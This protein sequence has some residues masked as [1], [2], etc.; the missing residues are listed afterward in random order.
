MKSLDNCVT[1]FTFN[2]R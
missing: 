1:R 2:N